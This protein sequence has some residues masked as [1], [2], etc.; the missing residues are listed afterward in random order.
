MASEPVKSF[1][2]LMNENKQLTG[3]IDPTKVTKM[4]NNE[5]KD[6]KK[7]EP[8]IT[9]DT[10][11]KVI[12]DSDVSDDAFF[13]DFF[14]EQQDIISRYFYFVNVKR[15]VWLF[16]NVF[17]LNKFLN[18][19]LPS[20]LPNDEAVLVITLSVAFSIVDVT[21]FF[22]VVDLLFVDFFAFALVFFYGS[23]FSFFNFSFNMSFVEVRLSF[24]SYFPYNQVDLMQLSL[25]I[26]VIVPI[27]L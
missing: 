11:A 27:I 4:D 19:E 23:S 22:D 6:Q 1:D 9:V 12:P 14:E 3:I 7:E 24:S 8:S 25:S 5:D 21:V 18:N 26:S 10:S 17:Y 15:A 16:Y 2:E 20:F 13:D